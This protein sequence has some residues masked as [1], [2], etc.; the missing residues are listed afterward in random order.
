MQHFP[1]ARRNSELPTCCLLHFWARDFT[2]HRRRYKLL[3][4]SEV[5]ITQNDS[6]RERT[7]GGTDIDVAECRLGIDSVF[8]VDRSWPVLAC[9]QCQFLTARRQSPAVVSR[10]FCLLCAA[11]PCLQPVTD[12][13][14]G[15]IPPC[16]RGRCLAIIIAQAVARCARD[17]PLVGATGSAGRKQVGIACCVSTFIGRR[18]TIIRGAFARFTV[19]AAYCREIARNYCLQWHSFIAIGF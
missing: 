1:G 17:S 16:R 12:Q 5:R 2:R 7:S 10:R 6:A 19:L 11:A 9:R 15:K 8:V 18:G 14:L 13:V 4:I 3:G